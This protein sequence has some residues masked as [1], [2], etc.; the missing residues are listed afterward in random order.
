MKAF[1]LISNMII[2][3]SCTAQKFP[4]E[5]FFATLPK[6]S[7][8]IGG[9]NVTSASPISHFV[10]GIYDKKTHFI[11]TGSLI[12]KNLVLTAAHCIESAASNLV[13]IF[14]LDF[15]AYDTN[16][17]NQ[18]RIGN[19][20]KVHP[21]YKKENPSD[22]DW[23]DLALIR[24]SGDLPEGYAPISLLEDSSQLKQGSTVQMAGF[25]AS[26]V[27]FD[28]ITIKKDK[29]FKQELEAGNIVCYDKNSTQCYSIH[30]LGSDQLR[31]TQAEIEGFTEKEFRLNEGH[32]HGTC[33]G[34]SGGPL[35]YQSEN[36]INL[37]GI[38]SRGSPFCDG[39]AIYTN[40]LEYSEWLEQAAIELK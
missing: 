5:K 36:K 15:T 2:L 31:A 17:L 12:R 1:F 14:G 24:F 19:A 28:E 35:I 11:C 9:T 37:I 7:P 10:V 8:I 29:K 16:D 32:G 3:I 18:L 33:V 30:F 25:G 38:T 23:N 27:E 39:P 4:Q 13:I 20:T 34:D 6:M 26:G 40:A 21:D 22:L